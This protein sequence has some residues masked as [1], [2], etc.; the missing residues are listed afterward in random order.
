MAEVYKNGQMGQNILDIGKND[1]ACGKGKL[2]HSDGSIY[3][4]EWLNDKPNEH[5]T[6]THIDGPNMLENGKMINKMGMGKN[7]GLMVRDMKDNIKMAKK[8]D[9]ENFIGLMGQCMKVILKIV[10]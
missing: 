8:V 2:V 10:I 5:G 7:F 3:E 6:Y 1:K 9:M 4:E